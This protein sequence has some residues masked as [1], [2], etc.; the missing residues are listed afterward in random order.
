MITPKS[1][2]Y[3]KLPKNKR[4][5]GRGATLRT[6]KDKLFIQKETQKLAIVGLGG[7]GKTQVA[8]QLAY[9]VRDDLPD[10]SV[11]WVSALGLASFE[12]AYTEMARQL[13]IPIKPKEDPKEAVRRYLESDTAGKW[14]L[15]VDNADDKEVIFGPSDKPGGIYEYLPESES[16]L[17]VFTTRTREVAVAV[18]ETD[19]I[20]LNEMSTEE[21]TGFFEKAIFDKKLLRDRKMTKELFQELTFLPL[22]ISQAAAYLNQNQ[23]SIERYLELLRSTEQDMVSLMSRE[24]HDNTRYRESKNAVASTW[25]VSFDQIR[26]FD[27]H[28]AELLSFISCIEW[29][30]IPQSILP[31]PPVE[32]EMEHAIGGMLT[33][34]I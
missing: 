6:L 29:K 24:F 27:S 17:T 2:Y 20:E 30:A 9:W 21:A 11:F 5:T 22:A 28:A 26:R 31:E 25:L 32:E 19:M 23:T 1:Q 4:F 7:V 3:L 33:P 34:S 12:Q 8:L 15:I 14:L 18:V 13:E 10:Y 16:G